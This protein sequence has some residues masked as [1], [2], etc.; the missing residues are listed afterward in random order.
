MNYDLISFDLQGTLTDSAFSDEFWLE[1]IPSVYAERHSIPLPEA[2]QQLWDRFK[3]YGKYD[4]RYY[5]V[6]YWL[7]ELHL[8][9]PF[10][11][12]VNRLHHKPR[13]FTPMHTLVRRLSKKYP[14]I[15]ISTTTREFIDTE[16]ADKRKFFLNAWSTLDDL[17]I[18]GKTA[19]SYTLI[20]RS[21]ALPP[22]RILHIGD[23]REMDA[24]NAVKA[25]Y[26]IYRFDPSVA[27]SVHSQRIGSMLPSMDG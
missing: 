22:E 16:L 15:I 2:K 23:S 14:L 12:I 27:V 24:D 25:G 4:S 3:Q 19:E 8:N 20:A 6:R 26:R 21:L 17:G 13:F 11:A 10:P 7:D 1:Y 5:S 18:A 9:E